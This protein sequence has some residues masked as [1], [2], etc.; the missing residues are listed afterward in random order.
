[1][2]TTCDHGNTYW[3]DGS[4]GRCYEVCADCGMYREVDPDGLPYSDV[5]WED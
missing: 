1:M 2:E 4:N 5:D 3:E